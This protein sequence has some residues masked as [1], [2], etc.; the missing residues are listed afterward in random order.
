M[1]KSIFSLQLFLFG[2]LLFSTTTA[3]VPRVFS[4]QGVLS[5]SQFKSEHAHIIT[6]TLYAVDSEDI[7]LYS[8]SDTLFIERNGLFTIQLGKD[9][10]LPTSLAFDKQYVVEFTVNGNVMPMRIPLQSVPYAIISEKVSDNSVELRHLSEGLKHKLQFQEDFKLGKGENTLAN[11]VG[12][13]RS[14]I[15]GGDENR[16]SANFSS[17]LGGYTNNVSGTYG[18]VAG[19]QSNSVSGNWSFV[20]GGQNNRAMGSWS[21]VTAG[22]DNT[23]ASSATYATIGGGITNQVG[24]SNG[25]ISGGSS[26]IVSAQG[27]TVSGGQSNRAMQTFATVS[28]GQNN[29]ASGQGSVIVG[30]MNNKSTSQYSI[31]S[32]GSN[33]EANGNH[34]VISGGMNND[35]NAEFSS[36]AGGNE[37]IIASNA[38]SSFISGGSHNKIN[39]GTNTGI[40]GS[41]NTIT[42]SNNSFVMGTGNTISNASNGI[43]IGTGNQVSGQNATAIGIGNIANA[44]NEFV[45]GSYASTSSNPANSSNP[46]FTGNKR[47]SVGIGSS[48]GQRKNAFTVFENGNT[49]FQGKILTT[50]TAFLNS[51]EIVNDIAVGGDL[52]VTGDATVNGTLNATGQFNASNLS[53]TNTG[54]VTIGTANGLSVSGQTLSLATA[55]TT[56]PGAMSASDKTKLDGIVTGAEVNVNAD[57]NA[58]SGDAE[59]LNKPTLGTM[60]AETANDYYTKS[61]TD[62]GFQVQD[63]DLTTVATI[64]TSDQQLKVKSDGS[65]LEWFTPSQSSSSNPV[66]TILSFAAATA[67]SGYLVCDGSAVS[68]TSYSDLFNVLGTTWGVGDGSTTFNIPDLRGRSQIGS[69]QGSSLTNRTLGQI[70]GAETHTLT[71]NE[72]PPHTHAVPRNSGNS[73]NVTWGFSSI[74]NPANATEQTRSTGDGQ[75]HNNMQPFSVVTFIIKY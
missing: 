27:G 64:G 67:P 47:F 6:T 22:R 17:I 72:I 28:G 73:G 50:E 75:P 7:S 39:S 2:L 25:T 1:F 30:G 21:S 68:R 20:G 3:Q 29:I 42:S 56:S 11:Y 32:G 15:S 71:V 23:I 43:G 66:G 69:G 61:Q 49:L 14:V 36:I 55:T 12:G 33:N 44:N 74:F 4:I 46:S 37:N 60:S 57:W 54:D 52:S 59:I 45:I 10:G 62:A 9:K 24:A 65:G 58:I 53:G 51:T 63:A 38:R 34:A 48:S 35:A 5:R 16:T 31:V 70:G 41:N 13:F 40:M 8:Q 26:N 19:G 18:T